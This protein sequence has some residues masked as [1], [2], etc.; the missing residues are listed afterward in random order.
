MGEEGLCTLNFLLLPKK[1]FF[2]LSTD[3][4]R[5]EERG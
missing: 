1:E 2:G 4:P 5:S 3:L